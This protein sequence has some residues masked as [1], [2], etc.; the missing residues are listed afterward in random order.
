VEKQQSQASREA[1][2]CLPIG[3]HPVYGLR[4]PTRSND[5]LWFVWDHHVRKSCIGKDKSRARKTTVAITNKHLPP[6]QG[7]QLIR[8][9]LMSTAV[10]IN[11]TES[12]LIEH[13][14]KVLEINFKNGI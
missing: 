9:T 8:S 2:V 14:K 5:Y 1:K 13:I 12:D 7:A 6:L 11:G 3:P 10:G 4:F